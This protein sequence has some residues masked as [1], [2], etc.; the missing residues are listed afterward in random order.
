MVSIAL[1]SFWGLGIVFFVWRSTWNQSFGNCRLWW[2]RSFSLSKY[3]LQCQCI[4]PVALRLG[5]HEALI[6]THEESKPKFFDTHLSEVLYPIR[7][8][9]IQGRSYKADPPCK[10]EHSMYYFYKA[11]LHVCISEIQSDPCLLCVLVS[12]AVETVWWSYLFDTHVVVP[13]CIGLPFTFVAFGTVHS[14]VGLHLQPTLVSLIWLSLYV[15]VKHL[16]G[17]SFAFHVRPQI[18]KGHCLL[19]LRGGL[20]IW[21]AKN[22]RQRVCAI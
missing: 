6:L 18:R 10:P 5:E 7:P 12:A 16:L 1:S 3:P 19:N 8:I 11:G 21:E 4:N 2:Y 15:F 14:P 13:S 17:H 22:W 20:P 9:L